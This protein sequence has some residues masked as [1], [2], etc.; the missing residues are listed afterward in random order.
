MSRYLFDNASDLVCMAAPD[1]SLLYVNNAWQH[2]LGYTESEA[3]QLR[4]LDLVHPE[5]RVHFSE[6][7]SRVLAGERIDHVELHFIPKT[8]PP[9]TVEANLSCT[10]KD[11]S[12]AV[13]RGIYRDVT[14]RNRVEEHLRLA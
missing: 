1:G 12:P 3:A 4:L 8:R 5:N 13:I 9:I 14:Q 2:G 10:F 6:V 7:L 11:G